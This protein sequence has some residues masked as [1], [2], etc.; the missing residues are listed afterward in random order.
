[1]GLAA[2]LSKYEQYVATPPSGPVV[3]IDVATITGW[4]ATAP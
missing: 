2:L 3:A 1:M 4:E